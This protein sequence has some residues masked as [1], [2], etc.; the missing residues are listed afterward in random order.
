MASFQFKDL[1]F[2]ECRD[3]LEPSLT[4]VDCSEHKPGAWMAYVR[5]LD[6]RVELNTEDSSPRGEFQKR[7]LCF[8][9]D[10]Q[11]TP[12]MV[13]QRLLVAMP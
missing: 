10:S 1:T 13:P 7:P 3:I 11:A 5:L 6:Y 8:L 12:K 9:V 4:K 2:L